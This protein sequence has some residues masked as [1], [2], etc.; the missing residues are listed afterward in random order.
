MGF[1]SEAPVGIIDTSEKS[2]PEKW[3]CCDCNRCYVEIIN[4]YDKRDNSEVTVRHPRI[5]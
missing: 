1:E 2:M 3:E 5:E 4:F